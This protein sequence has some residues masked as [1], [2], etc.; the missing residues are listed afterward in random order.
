MSAFP[1]FASPYSSVRAWL[2][3]LDR[4][5]ALDPQVIVPSHGRFVDRAQIAKYRDYLRAVQSRTRELKQEGKSS[6][7][8]AQTIQAELQARFDGMAQPARIA[9]AVKA[10]YAEASR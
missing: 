7:D 8:A 2:A 10:A 3:A 9:G 1:A 5:D 4:L 6:D